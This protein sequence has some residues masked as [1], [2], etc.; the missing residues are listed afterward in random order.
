[1]WFLLVKLGIHMIGPSATIRSANRA[2][3]LLTIAVAWATI[4]LVELVFDWWSE[5]LRK[6]GQET[7]TT[8]LQP[9]CS[10]YAQ[11]LFRERHD[12]FG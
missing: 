10:G 6:G 4:R 1:L 12:F 11:E 5:R 7:A 9:G 2:G 8:L 3:T